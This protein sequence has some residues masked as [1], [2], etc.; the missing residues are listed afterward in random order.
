M[1]I[2]HEILKIV[3]KQE[4]FLFSREHFILL[5]NEISFYEIKTADDGKKS[6][7]HNKHVYFSM[8]NDKDVYVHFPYLMKDEIVNEITCLI[9]ALDLPLDNESVV[10]KDLYPKAIEIMNSETIDT[11]KKYGVI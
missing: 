6:Y 8:K 7:L 2:F 3:P 1:K 4:V 10:G 11:L 5:S 9:V